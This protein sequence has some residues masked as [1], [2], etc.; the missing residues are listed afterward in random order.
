MKKS[1][2]L[3][4][5]ALVFAAGFTLPAFAGDT[6]KEMDHSGHV[7]EK[8]HESAI[9]GYRFAYHLLNMQERNTHHMMVYI[10]SPAGHMVEDAKVGFLVA[11]PDGAKQKRMTMGMKGAYGT[12]LDLTSKGAYTVKMKAVTGGKKLYDQFTYT[13]E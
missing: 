7:G 11:G 9:E 8:I 4:I 3:L 13:V 5:V 6:E 2:T 12:D 1:T 10:K